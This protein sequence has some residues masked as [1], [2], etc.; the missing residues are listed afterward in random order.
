MFYIYLSGT[1]ASAKQRLCVIKKLI[2]SDPEDKQELGLSLLD[3]TLRA[4]H[5]V[6]HYGFDFGAR[7]RDYGYSPKTKEDLHEW[8]GLFVDY[9]AQLAVSGKSISSRVKTLLAE[10]FRG[11]WMETPIGNELEAASKLIAGKG[12]WN[13]GWIAVRTTIRFDAK[14]M[15]KD[16][17][18]RLRELEELVVPRDLLEQARIYV[19]SSH[20]SSLDLFD[21][22]DDDGEG[23]GDNYNRVARAARTIGQK[24]ASDENVLKALLPELFNVDGPWLFSFAE[25]LADGCPDI[26]GMWKEFRQQLMAIDSTKRNYRVLCGFLHSIS[27]RAAEVSET[28]LTEAVTDQVVAPAFP[29]LQASVGIKTRGLARLR[30]SLENGVAPIRA[31]QNLAYGR[32]L[33]SVG[34]EDFCDLLRLM[35]SKSGGLVVAIK[36]LEMRCHSNTK[37]EELATDTMKSI[38]QEL[39][40]LLSFDREKNRSDGT[41]YGLGKIIEICFSNEQT[42]ANA[43]ILCKNLSQEFS[44]YRTSPIYYKNVLEALATT[45]PIAFLDVFLGDPVAREHLMARMF[46]SQDRDYD[47][48]PLSK[49]PE[50]RILAWCD[51]DPAVRYPIVAACIIPYGSAGQEEQIEWTPLALQM[52]SKTP[53][54]IAVLNKMRSSFSPIS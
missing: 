21:A 14:S 34:D 47:P 10:N 7:A 36:I 8:F 4:S 13:E 29:F 6:G 49:I 5:F 48:H 26:L 42:K 44:E 25:G 38:G 50:D 43:E 32:V 27:S 33:E 18:S 54:P 16:L 12:A 24:V 52:I 20:E 53:D 2:D 22:E 30:L 28:I 19:L 37:T 9:T 41:D 31:Y 11:L 46:F 45:Q 23:K 39:L 51:T 17:L 15:E 3:A 40:T 1:H 35:A